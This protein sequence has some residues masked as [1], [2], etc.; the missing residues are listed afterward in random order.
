MLLQ[1][2]HFLFPFIPLHPA[3]HLTPTSP[4][5]TSCPWVVHVSSLTSPFPI[6]FLTSPCLFCAYHLC[7]LF[8]VPVPPY[9][10]PT[11]IPP[12][13]FMSMGHTYKFFYFSISYTIL[14]LP[15]SIT[16]LSVLFLIP[17]TFSPPFSPLP[18]PTDNPPC[19]LYFCDSVPVL[20]VAQFVFVF[21][22]QLLIVVEFVVILLFI[23][24]IIFFFLDKSL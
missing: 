14:N 7:F 19:D 17:C 9:S 2:S 6:L 20:V 12:P 5:I 13:Q 3:Y 11:I 10:P 22:V 4:S 8:L 1:L 18:L 24:L 16:C 15:L 23:F 21:Q